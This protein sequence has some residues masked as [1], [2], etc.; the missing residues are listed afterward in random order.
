MISKDNKNEIDWK[1]SPQGNRPTLIKQE[2]VKNILW[3]SAILKYIKKAIICNV[4]GLFTRAK[5]THRLFM[6][7]SL[8]IFF[9]SV[10]RNVSKIINENGGPQ[11][12]FHQTGAEM[13]TFDLH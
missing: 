12:V 3:L 10:K 2:K 6:I 11:V 5:Q 13:K 1:E 7:H 8:A 9:I 4:S